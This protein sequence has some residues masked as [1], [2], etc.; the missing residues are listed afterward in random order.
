MDLTQLNDNFGI[1]GILVFRATV[2]GLTHA[3]IT[4]PHATA[5]VYLQGAHVT[6]W[7][8][9]GQGPAIFV[10]RKSDFAPG[11]P[12]RGGVPIAFP[13]FAARHD[14][15]TG[16][17]HGFAR[18]QDWTL[19]FAALAGED[20]HMTFTLGS[21][22]M[23]RGLGYD[24]FRLAFQVTIGRTLT[25]ELTVVNDAPTPLVFEEAL[26]TYYAVSDIHEISVVG[27][28]GV[29]YLDKNDGLRSKQ[30]QGPI[31]ITEPTDRVYLNTT[32][33]CLLQD[34]GNKRRI[35]VVKAG[36]NTT[37]VWNPW[38][39]GAAKLP[40]MDPTEWHEFIAIETVNAA[41]NAVSLSPGN[42]HV[43]RAHISVEDLNA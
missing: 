15:K 3:D 37:V 33:T 5:T 1:P 8:P 36:S 2:S 21:T 39:S 30:Q 9:K 28:E 25:M 26:H 29:T 31:T 38:E 4:T 11:K 18:I 13:W 32:G 20:L 35:R 42:T 34:A 22:E 12:I 10:S 43:M 41:T 7:Q 19:A 24:H 40:D 16:P 6:A 17:S 23:S 27:L 14:G